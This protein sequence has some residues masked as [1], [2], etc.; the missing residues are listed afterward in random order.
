MN[1]N[2]FIILLV[3]VVSVILVLNIYSQESVV[4][5][6]VHL[7]TYDTEDPIDVERQTVF[8][9]EVINKGTAPATNIQI[10]NIIPEPMAFVSTSP[11][12]LYVRGK[13]VV[14][15]KVK[16]LN[17]GDKITYSITCRAMQGGF[18]KNTAT[19]EYDE[20]NK[21]IIDEEVITI[22]IPLANEITVKDRDTKIDIEN[23]HF[24]KLNLKA[25]YYVNEMYYDK[26]N[27]YLLVRLANTFHHY[28]GLPPE[29]L[30]NWLKASS[31]GSYYNRNIKGDYECFYFPSY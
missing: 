11:Q 7:S 21:L 18:A 16:S 12:P 2:I 4:R 24:E 15:P 1:R 10:R 26:N 20:F 17:P 22:N 8:V 27:K 28:C 5:S 14:F 23:G 9:V 29:V 30:G 31:I 25:S 6:R 3:T 19:L 13:E